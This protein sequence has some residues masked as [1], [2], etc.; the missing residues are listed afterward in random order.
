MDSGPYFAT[1][2]TQATFAEG[3]CTCLAK[4]D[5]S[6]NLLK[7]MVLRFGTAVEA[8]KIAM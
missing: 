6:K 4:A 5:Q 2:L 8:D 3:N 7:N 1:E